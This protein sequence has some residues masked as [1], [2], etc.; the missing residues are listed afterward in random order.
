MKFSK[1]LVALVAILTFC[2]LF[3][4]VNAA[5]N[6]TDKIQY[7]TEVFSQF[8]QKW[9][10]L[11]A[12]T[13]DAYNS[14]TIGWGGMGTL[15][16]K[17]VVTVYVKPSRYTYKFLNDNEYFTV[18]FYS[19]EY[20]KALAVMGSKSGRDCDKVKEAGLTPKFLEKSTTFEQ[21]DVTILCKKVYYDDMIME[22]FPSDAQKFYDKERNEGREQY[23]HRMYIGEVIEIIRK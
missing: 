21:A 2:G 8:S 20:R 19:E 18:S 7:Q 14:M 9:A 15:W 6:K 11:T 22:R 16:G 23:P 12:G 17:P 10:L 5:E 3:S 4:S 1:I 13:K